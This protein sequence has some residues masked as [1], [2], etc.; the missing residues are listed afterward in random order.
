MSFL[1]ISTSLL[2]NTQ[3]QT[4]N[5]DT[6]LHFFNHILNK[7]AANANDGQYCNYVIKSL[8]YNTIQ[9]KNTYKAP[10]VTKSYS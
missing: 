2:A 9:Y 4:T 7:I 10:Y 3:L 5:T 8:E 1:L 6:Q